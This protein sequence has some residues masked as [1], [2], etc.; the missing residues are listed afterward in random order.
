MATTHEPILLRE[1]LECFARFPQ[2]HDTLRGIAQWWLIENR[3]EWAVADIQA[4]LDELVARSFIVAW[5]TTD[6]QTRYKI[7]P[8][9]LDKVATY[10]RN[11]VHR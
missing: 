5:R 11:D 6:G 9:Y 1:V 3:V 8:V 7:N 4:A 2:R 10:L